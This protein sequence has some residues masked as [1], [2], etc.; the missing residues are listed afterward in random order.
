[1]TAIRTPRAVGPYPIDAARDILE[2]PHRR[3]ARWGSVCYY[4]DRLY[5]NLLSQELTQSI[6]FIQGLE[7]LAQS[8]FQR[9]WEQVQFVRVC[10]THALTQ[11]VDRRAS[12]EVVFGLY[13]RLEAVGFSST[14]ALVQAVASLV[15]WADDSTEEARAWAR[16]KFPR[17]RR[18]LRRLRVTSR[19]RVGGLAHLEGSSHRHRG[20]RVVCGSMAGSW[21][22][23]PLH[24]NAPIW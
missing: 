20:G 16:S 23:H 7:A 12:F 15:P 9:H 4:F 19:V 3:D 8:K 1:M 2:R 21:P 22:H 18:Q 6:E 24:P 10:R 5:L 13:S 17:A 11:S 14:I